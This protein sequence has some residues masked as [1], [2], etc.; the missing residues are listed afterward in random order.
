M[1][2]IVF[3]AVPLF[4]FYVATAQQNMEA[5]QKKI[6][7]SIKSVYLD[8]Y[9]LKYPIIRQASINHEFIFPG[10]IR[11]KLHD[12]D[13]L[14]GRF[15]VS[16]I[17]GRFNI[18]VINW[19][20]NTI[21]ATVGVANQTFRITDVDKYNLP[22]ATPQKNVNKTALNTSVTYSH[23]DSL[24]GKPVI[25]NLSATAIFNPD[26]SRTRITGT[27]SLFFVLKRTSTNSLSVGGVFLIDPS[28]TVP[29]APVV[30]FWQKIKAI[31]ADLFIDL[32]YRIALRKAM[33]KKFSV[34]ALGELA[35]NQAF[36]NLEQSQLP[37]KS[38]YSTLDIKAGMLFEYQ[39]SKKAVVS[40]SGGIFK[41]VTSKFAEQNKNINNDYF[42]KN[43]HEM[44]PYLNAGIS[45]L[46]FWTGV[47]NR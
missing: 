11:T 31:D 26:F 9:A 21:T 35:G 32:P 30:S 39:L 20:K 45:L 5:I 4:T 15:A 2:R 43:Q 47:R 16:R 25:V 17:T 38:I 12:D 41:T 44:V 42:I 6:M 23:N 22:F 14:K 18:P 13:L 40:L 19:G 3:V 1:R 46:P 28:A 7:D 8:A 27:G 24:F 34:T 37:E 33:S 29:F 10:N 36:F